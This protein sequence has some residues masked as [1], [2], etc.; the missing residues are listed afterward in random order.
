MIASNRFPWVQVESI[1]GLRAWLEAD[2]GREGGV[3]LV[4]FKKNVPAGFV[5]RL[6]ALDELLCFGWVDGMGP[7]STMSAQRNSGSG[8]DQRQTQP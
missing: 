2:L 6:Y 7:G 4:R 3:W 1:A 8:A 5:D